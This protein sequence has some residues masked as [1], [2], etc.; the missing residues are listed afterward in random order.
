M[1][2]DSP[3]PRVVSR[4]AGPENDVSVARDYLVNVFGF[5]PE[6]V[7]V[8]LDEAATRDAVH[9]AFD[10]LSKETVPGDAVYVTL[11]RAQLSWG[12]LHRAI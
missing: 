4:L 11:E 9:G 5:S 12:H 8:L 6:D 1:G 2:G 7:T 3:G 10:R